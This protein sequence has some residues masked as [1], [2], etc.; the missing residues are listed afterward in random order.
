MLLKF[1]PKDSELQKL[2]TSSQTIISNSN[3]SQSRVTHRSTLNSK[4]A[5]T[6]RPTTNK[7]FRRLDPKHVQ[8]L[9]SPQSDLRY[10][11]M[12]CDVL[13]SETLRNRYLVCL[14]LDK[15]LCLRMKHMFLCVKP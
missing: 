15:L 3:L 8:S 5:L 13:Y 10:P 11:I 1:W 6:K 12:A 7:E 9:A 2:R 4:V 14:R